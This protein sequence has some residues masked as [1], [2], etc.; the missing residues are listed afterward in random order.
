LSVTRTFSFGNLIR[1]IDYNN[2]CLVVGQRNG[3]ITV[4]KEDSD[5]R[6]EVMHS[7]NE[8]EVW[9]LDV[10]PGSHIITSGDDNQVIYWDFNERK[11]SKGCEVSQRRERAA[12][13]G[14]STLSNLP[15][16]QCSRAVACSSDWIAVAGNDGS[17]SV[18][19]ASDPQTECHLLKDS[20]EWIEV[21]A[22][23]PDS[24]LLAVGSHDNKIYL[25]NTSDFSLESTLTG[26][27]SYVM[28]LDWSQDGSYVRSN[29]GAYELLFFS[30]AT[31]WSQ[32]ANGRSNTTGTDWATHTV[33]FGWHVQGIYPRG[34]DGSHINGVN[35]SEDGNLI[36]TGDDFGLVNIFRNPVRNGGCPRSLRGHSEHV[37][38][39]KFAEGDNYLFSIGGYDQTLMQWRRQ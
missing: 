29:C 22:F 17:V 10:V 21:M 15:D 1:A 11:K 18:R 23:N 2:G 19:A 36:A 33:K 5:E 27:T 3:T 31:G 26:H 16:S 6:Q 13:G 34:T 12:R 20:S 24:S 38:R 4:V 8:G 28:A 35:A 25:Y 30:A 9:G 39:V 32:D 7:H 14:A 37:V